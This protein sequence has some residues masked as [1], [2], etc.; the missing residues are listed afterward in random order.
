MMRESLEN[1]D[2]PVAE[3]LK[4]LNKSWEDNYPNR[5]NALEIA[6]RLPPELTREIALKVFKNHLESKGPRIKSAMTIL[7][8]FDI[9]K[10]DPLVQEKIFEVIIEK[11]ERGYIFE[12][13]VDYLKKAFSVS[14]E[15][16][17]SPNVAEAALKGIEAIA[18][19]GRRPEEIES[20]IA[21]IQEQFNIPRAKVAA[22][23]SKA[24][25]SEI[26]L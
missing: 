23:I 18:R 11:L 25:P 26:S 13:S 4:E 14:D 20:R 17:L 24:Q 9:P 6:S 5:D 8:I 10:D 2:N 1:P 7:D 12:G 15:V 22:A 3:L 19:S 21:E 16:L